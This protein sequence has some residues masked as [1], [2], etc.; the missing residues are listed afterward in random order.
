MKKSKNKRLHLF[1]AT[2]DLHMKYKLNLKKF[3]VLELIEDT[4][5]YAR[6]KI[7]D[8]EWS[9]EDG[10]RSDPNFIIKCFRL[11]T[12]YGA[13]T[14]NIADTVGYSTPTEMYKLVR[15]VFNSVEGIEKHNLSVHCHNDLGMATSNTLQSIKAGAN[16]VNVPLMV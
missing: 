4:M 7:D 10:T 16:Q 9:C 14:I 12:K 11:A 2:S 8:I 15:R 6:N 13:K 1:I 3:Q 5:K